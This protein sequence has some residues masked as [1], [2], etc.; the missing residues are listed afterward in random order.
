MD[1][2]LLDKIRSVLKKHGL[3]E[4]VIEEVESELSDDTPEEEP[5]EEPVDEEPAPSEAPVDEGEGEPAP[6]EDEPLP[7][8]VAPAEDVPVEPEA[9]VEEPLPEET[10]AE[11]PAVEGQVEELPKGVEEVKVG[12]E[13]EPE[14]P[15]VDGSDLEQ[16][17]ELMSQ[18]EEYK[19]ANEGLLARVEALESALK[20]SGIMDEAPKSNAPVGVD[21]G[22]RTPDYHDDEADFDAMLDKINK[23][24]Y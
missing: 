8:D 13:P 23:G 21:D 12:A 19:K 10:P 14:A 11:E 17:G 7:E 18:L 4:E 16:V 20:E 3:E 9:P 24:S 1:E 2:K 6:A 22:T 15:A 5:T